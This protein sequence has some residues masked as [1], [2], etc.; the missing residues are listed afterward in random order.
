MRQASVIACMIARY[1][2]DQTWCSLGTE[3]FCLRTAASGM[4]TTANCSTGLRRGKNSGQVLAEL[5]WRIGIIWECA[6]KGRGRLHFPAVLE[7][8][9]LW[10]RS[11]ER[12]LEIRGIA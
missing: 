6:L 2:A 12:R 1:R 10:L 3:P 4:A 5:G 7:T 9:A 8:C 11:E